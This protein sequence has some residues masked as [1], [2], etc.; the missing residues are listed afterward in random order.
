MVFWTAA[1]LQDELNAYKVT[2]VTQIQTETEISSWLTNWTLDTKHI[3]KYW[4]QHRWAIA[5][6]VDLAIRQK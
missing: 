1:R 3:V 4:H 5:P 6:R 2:F